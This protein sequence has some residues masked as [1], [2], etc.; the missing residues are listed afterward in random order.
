MVIREFSLKENRIPRIVERLVG[1]LHQDGSCECEG[2]LRD[3]RVT[4]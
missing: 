1:A 2:A 3:A 4:R